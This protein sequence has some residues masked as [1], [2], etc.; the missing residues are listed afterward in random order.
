MAQGSPGAD[1]SVPV[2]TVIAGKTLIALAQNLYGSTPVFW[3]RY[4]TSAATT[5]VVEYRHLKENQILFDNNIRVL[6]IARQTKRVDGTAAEG[7]ADATSNAEDLIKTF[8]QDYLASQGGKFFMFLDAEGNP[9]LSLSYYSGW[10]NTLT[11]YSSTF[12]GRSVQVMPCVYA[13]Q[14][15]NTTWQNLA[16]GCAQ[17]VDCRGIWV[18]R[19]VEH[20][21]KNLVDWN[22]AKVNPRIALPC[23]VLIWQYSA[24]CRG[25]GGFDCEEVNPSIDLDD[26]LL[27]QLILPPSL[28]G[29][30]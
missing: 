23:K 17:G 24:D 10:A 3:G 6:P 8:G 11:A 7:S 28:Q 12:S 13:S 1:S 21:C 5:G 18:A 22:D 26:D 19:W 20:G 9:P 14:G 2:T 16:T 30:I 15:D 25:G 4:F 27:N 29:F